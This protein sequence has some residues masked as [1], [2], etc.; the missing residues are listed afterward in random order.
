MMGKTIRNDLIL[1][2][3]IIA[4]L[5][6]VGGAFLLFRS[7][8]DSVVVTVNGE[9]YATYP[10]SEDTEVDILTGQ[11]HAQVNHLV[12]KE[13]KAYVET[14]TCP[15]GICAS[16]RPISHDGESIICIPHKVVVSVEAEK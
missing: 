13:G 16:H 2:G 14:A 8:G 5:L 1:I 10:L 7:E 3:S 9:V 4:V 6:I 11:N 12:I 15:D